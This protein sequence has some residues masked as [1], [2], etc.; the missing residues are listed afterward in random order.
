[1]TASMRVFL[2]L[3]SDAP[4][5]PHHCSDGS[6]NQRHEQENDPAQPA[7]CFRIMAAGLVQIGL[8]LFLSG[9]GAYATAVP[10]TSV[11]LSGS[12]DGVSVACGAGTSTGCG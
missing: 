3:I 1:M 8:T 4:L 5:P 7:Q 6:R 11:A 12:G 2:Q 10:S 9:G